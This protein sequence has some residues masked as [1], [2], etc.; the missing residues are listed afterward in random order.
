MPS[1]GGEYDETKSFFSRLIQKL[2][3][4][5]SFLGLFITSSTIASAGTGV[6]VTPEDDFGEAMLIT[7]IVVLVLSCLAIAVLFIGVVKQ[8]AISDATGHGESS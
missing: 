1:A 5:I 7:V 2:V 3:L 4:P 8:D 6:S